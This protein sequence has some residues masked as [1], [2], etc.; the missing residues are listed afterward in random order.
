MSYHV[1]DI[2]DS[3]PERIAPSQ[4]LLHLCQNRLLLICQ[5]RVYSLANGSDKVLTVKQH[6]TIHDVA[7]KVT[8]GRAR[9]EAPRKRRAQPPVIQVVFIYIGNPTGKTS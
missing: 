4:H 7:D 9:H 6:T 1:G 3:S 2:P 5:H 8:Q